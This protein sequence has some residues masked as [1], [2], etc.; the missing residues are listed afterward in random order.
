MSEH[1]NFFPS[2]SQ[3]SCAAEDSAGFQS[4]GTPTPELRHRPAEELSQVWLVLRKLTALRVENPEDAEDLVQETFVT[5][6]EKFCQLELRKGL[7]VWSMGILRRKLG[8][9]YRKPKRF[10]SIDQSLHARDVVR[11]VQV[12]ASAETTLRESELHNLVDQILEEFPS[13]ERSVLKLL[14]DGF[15]TSEIAAELHPERYQNVVNRLHRGRKRLY[16][17]LKKF[18]YTIPPQPNDRRIRKPRY[19]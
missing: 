18:G 13:L 14:F 16:K 12:P 1:K 10:A 19:R 17:E 15:S 5:M 2:V 6:T 4:E 3:D 7:L 8:N 9:Y 11:L